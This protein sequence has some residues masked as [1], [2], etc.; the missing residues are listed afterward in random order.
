LNRAGP[1]T[2]IIAIP[3]ATEILLGGSD[4]RSGCRRWLAISAAWDQRQNGQDMKNQQTHK[5]PLGI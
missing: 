5:N 3:K 2:G 4:R 1:V